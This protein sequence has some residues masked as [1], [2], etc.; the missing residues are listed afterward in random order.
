MIASLALAIEASPPRSPARPLQSACRERQKVPRRAPLHHREAWRMPGA[1][2]HGL[3][4]TAASGCRGRNSHPGPST[5][6]HDLQPMCPIASPATRRAELAR[7]SP[8]WRSR[9]R[10]SGPTAGSFCLWSPRRAARRAARTAP[11]PDPSAPPGGRPRRRWSGP[12]VRPAGRIR[13]R[14][15]RRAAPIRRWDG[16]S[17]ARRLQAPRRRR[18]RRDTSK[19]HG[20]RPKR[21]LSPL[22]DLSG[23]W[24][25][26]VHA[27]R[28]P[29]GVVLDMDS[30]V[31][32]THGEQE[33][34]VLQNALYG[35]DNVTR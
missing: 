15:R 19:R 24:I 14:Q 6:I 2:A 25:D 30:S 1:G 18:A 9:R 28:P 29:R 16:S 4:G 26:R 10:W 5:P 20:S 12:T 21:T 34:S 22:V 17:A 33:M 7:R 8:I 31:S 13:G 32:R 27:L 3:D 35:L 11:R 23:Q